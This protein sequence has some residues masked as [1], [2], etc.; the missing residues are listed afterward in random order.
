MCAKHWTN[1]DGLLKQARKKDKALVERLTEM[2]KNDPAQFGGHV[3]TYGQ[4]RLS[5]AL[6]T[7]TICR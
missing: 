3:D 1:R 5:F 2:E 4:T 7:N 6:I